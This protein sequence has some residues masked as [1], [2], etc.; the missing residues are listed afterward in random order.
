MQVNDSKFE[1]T[2]RKLIHLILVTTKQ[3]L[4]RLIYLIT[5]NRCLGQY[6]GQMADEF[7][8]R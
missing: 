7:R 1:I 8:H 3:A 4:K 5:C 6:L 2:L